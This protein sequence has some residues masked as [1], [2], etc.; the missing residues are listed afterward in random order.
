M[1]IELTDRTSVAD[2]LEYLKERFPEMIFP[3]HAFLV[4]VNDKV[5]SMERILKNDDNVTFLP[6]VGGG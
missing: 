5:S 3:E 6:L 2:V 4:A 1:Q